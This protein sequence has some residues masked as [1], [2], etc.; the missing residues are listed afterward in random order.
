MPGF[1]A[2]YLLFLVEA[3]MIARKL[4]YCWFGGRPMP[5]QARCSL[6]SWAYHLPDYEVVRWDEQ[7]FDPA[8]HPFT[9]AAYA[10]GCYAFVSDYVRMFAL[11]QE[12]GIY[13][14]VDVEALMSLDDC[15]DADFF[16]GLE[17]RKRF[18]TSLLGSIAGHWL[19][20]SMLDYYDHTQFAINR[21]SDLVN[22]N[23][24]SRLLIEAGFNGEGGNE[25]RGREHIYAIGS[26]G[27]SAKA[28]GL[29]CATKHYAR[30]LFAGTWRSRPGKSVPSRVW[31]WLR[32]VPKRIRALAMLT[33]YRLGRR[34][35]GFY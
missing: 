21:A 34:L 29:A 3:K 25:R 28:A 4:H 1:L 7:S 23:E 32:K 15:L 35:R 11:A 12:G 24:V 2:L 5:L 18:G 9:S 16:I 10:A 13:L 31:R 22:V 6:A 8:S 26:F 20:L 14:D 19:P 30:H 27:V 17:D 33:F